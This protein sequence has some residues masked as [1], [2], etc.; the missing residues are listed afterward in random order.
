MIG[1][2]FQ[3]PEVIVP[4]EVREEPMT[5]EFSDVPVKVVAA[6]VI[7]MFAEPSNETPLIVCGVVRVAADVADE[8]FPVSAPTNVVEVTDVKPA[9]V[10]ADVPRAI[11]VEPI[12]IDEFVS[13]PFG[14]PVKFV[15]VSVG[16]V[17]QTGAPAVSA[18]TP[19]P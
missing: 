19:V 13:A 10:V 4:T 11:L 12:V 17:V 2:A 6:A 14:I 9:M 7:V 5:V 15:P 8:A 18:R 3:V 16:A 1:V